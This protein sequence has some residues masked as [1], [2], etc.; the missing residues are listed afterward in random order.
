MYLTCTQQP[1]SPDS[2]LL[3][4]D[5]LLSYIT[6]VLYKKICN[7]STM[8]E[9]SAIMIYIVLFVFQ[10]I[11]GKEKMQNSVLTWA[12]RF[13][14]WLLMFGGFACLTSIV[15]TVGELQARHP[16]SLY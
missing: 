3:L 16:F 8:M 13:G 10:Q 15:V 14:G 7:S 6:Y 5:I 4:Y 11:F 12:I 1:V 2:V 9:I